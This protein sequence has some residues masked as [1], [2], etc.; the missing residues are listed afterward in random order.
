ETNVF[1]FLLEVGNPI[2]DIVELY[3]ILSDKNSS[4]QKSGEV[5]KIKDRKYKHQN[6]IFSLNVFKGVMQTFLLK[7]RSGELIVIPLTIGTS[8][9]ILE[10]FNIREL[11]FGIYV[12]IILVMFLYNL[13]VYLTVRDRSYLYYII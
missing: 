2:L 4:V 12:G 1:Y 5:Q 13:F 8:I 3:T 10:S 6:F 11:L 7:V 9:T